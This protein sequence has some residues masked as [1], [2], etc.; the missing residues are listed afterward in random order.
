M[1]L[2]IGL[3]IVLLFT[4]FSGFTQQYQMNNIQVFVGVGSNISE[5]LSKKFSN[6]GRTNVNIGFGWK[7]RISESLELDL[8]GGFESGKT[9]FK[10]V[11]FE[12]SRGIDKGKIVK[13]GYQH[14]F[15]ITTF[16]VGG[17]LNWFED[18]SNKF[19]T[20]VALGGAYIRTFSI[21]KGIV[22]KDEIEKIS[23]FRFAY[24]LT[25]IG[26]QFNI[27]ESIGLSAELGY[28]YLGILKGG[29]NILF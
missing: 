15:Y 1:Q 20:G 24:Q 9:G 14:E 7:A 8:T 16:L 11:D 12:I 29:L 17:Y 13:G 6:T 27:T 26:Y 28:G 3:F 19:Y 22:P 25:G 5:T 4:F 21:I 23:G 18:N 10:P 2:R